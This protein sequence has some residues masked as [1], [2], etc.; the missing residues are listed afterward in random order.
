MR[1]NNAIT[2]VVFVPLFLGILGLPRFVEAENQYAPGE[3]LVKFKSGVSEAEIDALVTS[4]GASIIERIAEMNVY[5]L[6]I[7]SGNSV[8]EMVSIFD[9]DPKCEYAE[10]N[11]RGKVAPVL[12]EP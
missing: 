5:R 3:I 9:R 12:R 1:N 10:P 6:K 8:T 11:Y 4:Y 2:Y 7:P